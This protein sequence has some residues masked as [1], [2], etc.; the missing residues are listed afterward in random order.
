MDGTVKSKLS[1]VKWAKV[2]AIG[3]CGWFDFWKNVIS[4]LPDWFLGS[5]LY[6]YTL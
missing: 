6:E 5:A 4:P 1:T 2:I 3:K